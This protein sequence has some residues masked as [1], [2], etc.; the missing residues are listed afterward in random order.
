L[1]LDA[2]DDLVD[3]DV[4]PRVEHLV[5]QCAAVVEVPVEPTLGDAQRV[6]ELLDAHRI[7]PADAEGSQALVDPAGSGRARRSGHAFCTL[8]YRYA[9]VWKE[10]PREASEQ[11][12]H[13]APV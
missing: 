13:L 7:G 5:E 3:D 11:R 9:A 6:G 2:P 4:L 10:G 1:A 12:P 8:P